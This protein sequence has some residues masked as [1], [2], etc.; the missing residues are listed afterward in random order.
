VLALNL[1]E[2]LS[3]PYPG[4]L[5]T[6]PLLNDGKKTTLISMGVNGSD[7]LIPTCD[8]KNINHCQNQQQ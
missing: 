6:K 5:L 4:E 1:E 7:N 3:S 2:K 8:F